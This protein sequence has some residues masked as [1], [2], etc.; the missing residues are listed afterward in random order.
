MPILAILWIPGIIGLTAAPE[1]NI[2]GTPLL[3][4][5][6]WRESPV[7][8]L[9]PKLRSQTVSVFWGGF[10]MSTAAFMML[11]RIWSATVGSIIPSA[12]KYTDVIR[13]LGR[14][15]KLIPWTAAMWVSF[16]PLILNH[17]NAADGTGSRNSLST[18]AAILFGIFLCT[19]V[20]GAEKLVVQLIA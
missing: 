5:S 6:I 11:P 7:L 19:I 12:R 16:N 8:C 17:T 13:A 15:A 18:F 3:W 9:L 1:G 4:W 2:W 10:W 20:Y 14:Y